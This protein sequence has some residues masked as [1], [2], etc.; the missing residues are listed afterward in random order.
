M[1]F[2]VGNPNPTGLIDQ[3]VT[4]E[5]RNPCPS[6]LGP[7]NTSYMWNLN[8]MFWATLTKKTQSLTM[9]TKRNRKRHRLPLQAFNNNKQKINCAS[10]LQAPCVKLTIRTQNRYQVVHNIYP[11]QYN[12]PEKYMCA[13]PKWSGSEVNA[14]ILYVPLVKSGSTIY[15]N[16]TFLYII[17]EKPMLLLFWIVLFKNH[18]ILFLQVMICEKPTLP[19]SNYHSRVG[20]FSR[21]SSLQSLGCYYFELWP[22][23]FLQCHPFKIVY[24]TSLYY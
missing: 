18:M 19:S 3:K 12:D 7:S 14:N 13:Y 23:T 21:W 11:I 5:K 4:N 17:F 9:L 24:S 8:W 16:V 15:A 1:C 10:V 2:E 20:I 6:Y 22:S